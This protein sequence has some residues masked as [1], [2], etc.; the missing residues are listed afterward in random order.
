ME[1]HF[2]SNG[3]VIE[4]VNS[5]CYL[6]IMLKCNGSFN[7]AMSTLAEKAK[8]TYLY[9]NVVLAITMPYSGQG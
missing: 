8:K 4:T 3:N 1:Y 6:G 5:Y 7:L 2:M 9:N